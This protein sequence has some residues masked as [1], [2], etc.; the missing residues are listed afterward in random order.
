MYDSLADHL[1]ERNYYFYFAKTSRVSGKVSWCLDNLCSASD[2]PTLDEPSTHFESS[3]RLA[4]KHGN[5]NVKWSDVVK[6]DWYVKT[7]YG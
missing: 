2:P 6:H 3:K 7:I 5:E 4:W 1:N